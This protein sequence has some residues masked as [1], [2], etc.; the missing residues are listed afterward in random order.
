MGNNSISGQTCCFFLCFFLGYDHSIGV[1]PIFRQAPMG[2][3]GSNSQFAVFTFGSWWNCAG[4]ILFTIC[5]VSS[6]TVRMN[7]DETEAKSW[8]LMV[9]I[10][11]VIHG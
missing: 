6:G 3:K 8:F 11:L 10:M 1:Q 2:S 7:D 4:P 9:N 5:W